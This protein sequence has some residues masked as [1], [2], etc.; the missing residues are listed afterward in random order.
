MSP[1]KA[2]K[3][4]SA[5]ADHLAALADLL[6]TSREE[7]A[8]LFEQGLALLVDR[9]DV[10]R[11]LLTR[12]TALGYEVFWW[13]VADGVS[14]ASVFQAPEKGFCPWVMAHPDRPLAIR[15]AATESRWQKSSGLLE[16][17][18]R[19]YAGVALKD[20]EN[21]VGTLC[22]QHHAPKAFDRSETE[23][24]RAMGHLMARALES[25]SLK[26]EL[27]G[28]IE[29]LELSGAI[30]EDSALQS[31]RSGMPNRRYL[32]IWLR[33]SLFM[34]RR[35]KE[36]IALALWSQPMVTGTKGR[37]AAAAAHLRGED[38]LI[39]LSV[40]QYL[41]IMPHTSEEGAEVLLE[42]LRG[43]LG[44]HPTGATLWFPDENDMTLKSALTRAGK[45]FTAANRSGKPLVWNPDRG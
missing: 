18:I 37:L 22:V 45:G 8:H 24:I 3:R 41:L 12:V 34:A 6:N 16:L 30:V 15:N 5:K 40:D 32:D 25:E 42:R 1:G 43:I 19:A 29:A 9:L 39:E 11:A 44:Q 28:A 14:M 7:P 21:V 33:A 2:L 31:A 35:R 27:R 4:R 20:G 10:D 23:L 38:L 17:G 26:Q 36:P 13:A